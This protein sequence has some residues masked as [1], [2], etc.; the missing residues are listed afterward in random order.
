M[1]GPG[2]VLQHPKVS[3]SRDAEHRHP[4]RFPSLHYPRWIAINERTD[5]HIPQGNEFRRIAASSVLGWHLVA[6]HAH[7]IPSCRST[8]CSCLSDVA[9]QTSECIRFPIHLALDMQMCLLHLSP[10]L[11]TELSHRRRRSSREARR[12][13]S[14]CDVARRNRV[15][16]V[17][18]RSSG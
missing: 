11:S 16:E 3:S 6:N 13:A 1:S 4:F 10:A 8:S 17:E 9:D 15:A 7:G 5:L 14:A 2:R 12:I 18:S